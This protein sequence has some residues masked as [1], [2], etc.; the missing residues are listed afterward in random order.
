MKSLLVAS[1]AAIGAFAM[2]NHDGAGTAYG[3]RGRRELGAHDGF[4]RDPT[5]T[6]IPARACLHRA[7]AA[8]RSGRAL[9]RR[10]PAHAGHWRIFGTDEPAKAISRD[11]RPLEHGFSFFS[12]MPIELRRVQWTLLRGGLLW[13]LQ[14]LW[15]PVCQG[16][17][18]GV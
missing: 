14:R 3:T 11:L 16:H 2:A 6:R 10:R 17:P 1:L 7:G 4:Q 15:L 12:R 18:D 8:P 13:V 9:P 5:V